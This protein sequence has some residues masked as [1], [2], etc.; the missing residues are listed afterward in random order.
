MNQAPIEEFWATT[1]GGSVFRVILG[2]KAPIVTKIAQY[3]DGDSRKVGDLLPD[4]PYLGISKLNGL[5]PYIAEAAARGGRRSAYETNMGRWACKTAPLVGLF[6]TEEQARKAFDD[7]CTPWD[8][9]WIT[10]S[11]EVL[12]AIPA[13]HAWCVIDEPVQAMMKGVSELLGAAT[14]NARL[15]EHLMD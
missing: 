3:G 4:G 13:D 6:P 14:Q 10:C 7:Q 11:L 12:R 5:I 9:R 15:V 2:D 8:W 1:M